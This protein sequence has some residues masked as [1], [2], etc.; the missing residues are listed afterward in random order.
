MTKM[1]EM[2]PTAE[3]LANLVE[4]KTRRKYD[5]YLDDEILVESLATESIDVASAAGIIRRLL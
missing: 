1:L 3:S 2:P 4:P 5:G